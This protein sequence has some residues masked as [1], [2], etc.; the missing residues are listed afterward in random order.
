[1]FSRNPLGPVDDISQTV[2]T[3]PGNR[4]AG[5]IATLA[6]VGAVANTR[7]VPKRSATQPLT[8]M[9]TARLSV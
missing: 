2:P 6:L 8:G 9:N 7:L 1:M 4:D 5:R 3:R